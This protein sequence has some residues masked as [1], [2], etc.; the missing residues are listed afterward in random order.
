MTFTNRQ[1]LRCANATAA[2]PTPGEKTNKQKNSKE[3]KEPTLKERKQNKKEKGFC[4]KMGSDESRFN[5]SLT[6]RGK[7]TRQCPQFTVFEA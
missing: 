3:A 2:A 5:V 6:V 4:I 7:L 1:G